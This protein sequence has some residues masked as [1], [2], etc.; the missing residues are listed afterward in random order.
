MIDCFKHLI[1]RSAQVLFDFV[2]F[3]KL[4]RYGLIYMITHV[5]IN[6]YW[7][8][9]APNRYSFSEEITGLYLSSALVIELSALKPRT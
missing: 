8:I 2:Q 4:L 5:G 6:R 7:L 1:S 9:F 3:I